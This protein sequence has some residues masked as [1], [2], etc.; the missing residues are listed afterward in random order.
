MTNYKLKFCDLF[1]T[2]YS[3]MKLHS[4][5]IFI[6]YEYMYGK[7]NTYIFIYNIYMCT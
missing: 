5:Y 4:I 7:K 1:L 3:S 2:T 6:K